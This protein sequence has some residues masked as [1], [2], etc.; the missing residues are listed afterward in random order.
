MDR[1]REI[2]ARIRGGLHAKSAIE[3]C[4]GSLKGRSKGREE[5]RD[6][7]AAV[8]A[9]AFACRQEVSPVSVISRNRPRGRTRARADEMG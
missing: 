5:A 1:G 8:A 6:Y 3:A 2:I 4:R 7:F 9:G